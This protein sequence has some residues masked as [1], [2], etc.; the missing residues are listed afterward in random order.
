MKYLLSPCNV[1]SLLVGE[2]LRTE[3]CFKGIILA[4]VCMHGRLETG[5]TVVEK[6]TERL[7][8]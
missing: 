6:T 2:A 4:G 7:C 8:K 3:P 1:P 5:E